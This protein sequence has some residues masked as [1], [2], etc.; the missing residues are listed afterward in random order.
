MIVSIW[1]FLILGEPVAGYP[2]T[3]YVQATASD[4]THD[5]APARE[6]VEADCEHRFHEMFPDACICES[7]WQRQKVRVMGS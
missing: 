6:L 5:Y 2:G 4:H 7:G 1:V 3:P